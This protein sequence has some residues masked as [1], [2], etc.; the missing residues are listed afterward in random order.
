MSNSPIQVR[1]EVLPTD[2]EAVR[3]IVESTGFFSKAEADVAA[4]LVEERLNKGI[5][6]GYYFLFAEQDGR[7][8][9]Y[10]C[11]GPIAC[12]LF[13]Y[14]LYWIAVEDA[15]RGKGLGGSFWRR[16][17]RPSPNW[18]DGGFTSKLLRASS[19]IPR[20]RS[21]CAVITWKPRS[22]KISMH[23]RLQGYHLKVL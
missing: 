2:V 4:E 13:S 14:D 23:R 11:F 18:G 16:A 3:S 7:V 19:T 17:K 20:A 12:T 5:Q 9:G 1:E 6:S 15:F 10:S 22:W 21:T 8:V